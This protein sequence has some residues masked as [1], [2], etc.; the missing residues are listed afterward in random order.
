MMGHMSKIEIEDKTVESAS[1]FNP[2]EA[3]MRE[4]LQ[5]LR[6]L[7][8]EDIIS[9]EDAKKMST[10]V[11][12]LSIVKFPELI[13]ELAMGMGLFSGQKEG[14]ELL[15]A[16][17]NVGASMKARGEELDAWIPARMKPDEEEEDEE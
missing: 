11:L 10:S 14:E 9:E 2:M 16:A 17:Q 6:S 1:E 7:A 5:E 8:H 4:R 3:G 13:G 15:L 12:V